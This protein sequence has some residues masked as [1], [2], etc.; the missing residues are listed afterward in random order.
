MILRSFLDLASEV[1]WDDLY[2]ICGEVI[3]YH[4]TPW[5]TIPDEVFNLKMQSFS[6]EALG[7]NV[8][9]MKGVRTVLVIN[10]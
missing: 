2:I 7:Y 9:P 1:F 6:A 3:A 4:Y 8:G 5:D 10:I